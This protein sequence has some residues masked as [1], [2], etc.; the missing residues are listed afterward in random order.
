[1]SNLKR[2]VSSILVLAMI[3][4]SGVFALG[5]F[6]ADEPANLIAEE[7]AIDLRENDF[8]V[9]DKLKTFGIID[10]FEATTL[11]SI[12][13]R[14]DMIGV[15]M[16]Y[17]D[18]K[19][20][21]SK[22]T[23]SPFVDVGA[24][25]K[26]IDAYNFLY[27]AGYISGD[28]NRRFNPKKALTYNEAVTFLINAMGYKIFAARNGGY[29]EGYLYTANKY[30]LLGGLRGDGNDPL[31]Y[32][33]LYILID[34]SLAADAVVERIYT[35][36]GDAQFVLREGYTVLEELFGIKSIKGIVTGSENTRL[37]ASDSSLINMNQIEID[38]VVY[39][40]GDK[41]FAE[42]LGMYVTAYGKKNDQGEYDI[43]FLEPYARRN[44]EY[45]IS[46]ENL[47][48]D[49]TT[50]ERIYYTDEEYKEKHLK[51]KTTTLSVIY[52]G[53]MYSGY[54]ALKN[55]LPSN[56]F[57]RGLDNTGD[58]VIDVLF[59][60]E[61]ENYV[62]GSID[63]FDQIYYDK[64][65]PTRYISLDTVKHDVRVYGAD[66]KETT[67]DMIAVGDL[68]SV[69]RSENTGGYE[70]ISVYLC[71]ETVN[72]TV[73]DLLPNGGYVIEGETYY[74]AQNTLDYVSGGE[75]PP[76]NLGTSAVYY[77]DLEGK[78]ANYTFS[79]TTDNIY[80]FIAGV[81]SDPGLNKRISLKIFTS[82]AKWVDADTVPVINIDGYKYKLSSETEFATA[83]S[84]IPVGEVVL[85]N[86]LGDKVNYIDTAER[87][88]GNLTAE[89]DIGNLNCI[90]SGAGFYQRRGVCHNRSNPALDKFVLGK[91]EPYIVFNTPARGE[92]L[93]DLSQYS[94][95]NKLSSYVYA[96]T[97]GSGTQVVTDGFAAYNLGKN[98][99]NVAKC[100]LLRGTSNATSIGTTTGFSVITK[101]TSAIDLEGEKCTKMYY[102]E[103]GVEK[104]ALI[105]HSISYGNSFVEDG[106][107]AEP[108]TFAETGLEVGDIVR[109]SI[110][111]DGYINAIDAVYRRNQAGPK[112]EEAW[113]TKE[114]SNMDMHKTKGSSGCGKFV[115]YD[116]V[117]KIMQIEIE[118]SG[119]TKQYNVMVD[120]VA[121][122]SYRH[123]AQLAEP[124]TLAD[125]VPGDWV[126]CRSNTYSVIFHQIII[127]K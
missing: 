48:V 17:L 64:Y 10:S 104:E 123:S 91:E 71:G 95:T 19:G 14:E 111:G 82:D 55:A 12:A 92:L 9:A 120:N 121:I 46:A 41:M 125:L 124:A 18:V 106:R 37:M 66:G 113:L 70:L 85:F 98:D 107:T 100:I 77:L 30:N 26:N 115:T 94:I 116:P 59:V 54:G 56:G 117:N 52:N 27:D 49:K 57:I 109:L 44:N 23:T 20:A 40:T 69:M 38:G 35:G 87:N 118:A 81:D 60:Y 31:P 101:L 86:L 68:I 58:E 75:L 83:V 80:G 89:A 65:D 25:D 76:V 42:Y 22:A 73:T 8:V 127:L 4:T 102:A 84:K 103:N 67:I 6:A 7:S 28:E 43:L 61:F 29:P 122:S 51:V 62:V 99:F 47:L 11:M 88:K 21:T 126:V 45:E 97:S 96:S 74:L 114:R 105:A 93:T 72:G 110:D 2:M 53:K 112:A 16:S 108:K 1:M 50:N 5:T 119:V 15:L 90:A 79:T 24:N 32:C 63:S 34:R 3:A 36:D 39:E 33:D 78:I 13:K